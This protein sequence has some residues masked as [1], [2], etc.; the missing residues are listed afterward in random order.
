M[1]RGLSLS[2]G[3]FSKDASTFVVK[4]EAFV[5]YRK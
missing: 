4:D 2:D 1:L 5:K 3:R